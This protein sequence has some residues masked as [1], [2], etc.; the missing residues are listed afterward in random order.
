MLR[1]HKGDNSLPEEGFSVAA[2]E[3]EGVNQAYRHFR[4]MQTGAN[5]GPLGYGYYEH[6]LF[7]AGIE[8]WGRLLS[9]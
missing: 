6:I 7:C 8:L 9:K 4:I 3:V 5:S 1:V 2:W